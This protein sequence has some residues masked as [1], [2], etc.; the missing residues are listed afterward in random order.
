MTN[1]HPHKQPPTQK[2][3]NYLR[4]LS[5]SRGV[6]FV[7]P[8]SKAE[9]S[10]EIEF[11]RTRRHSSHADRAAERFA[12]RQIADRFGPATAVRPEEI[13]GYGST[14]RWKR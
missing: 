7:V 8:G 9:A 3:L 5:V 2:Q 14:A 4:S 6:T 1:S 12:A 10:R 13:E 11:L